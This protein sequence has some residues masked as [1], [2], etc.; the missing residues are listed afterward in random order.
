MQNIGSKHKIC[1]IAKYNVELAPKNT[2]N[3]KKIHSLKIM[4]YILTINKF[5]INIW[6]IIEILMKKLSKKNINLKQ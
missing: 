6:T 3:V 1:P 4:F 2:E 5:W